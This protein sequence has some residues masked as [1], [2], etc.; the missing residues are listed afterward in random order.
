MNVAEL[1]GRSVM[2][3]FAESDLRVCT[4]VLFPVSKIMLRKQRD[5]K[6]NKTK[7]FLLPLEIRWMLLGGM[8]GG[9]APVPSLLCCT[10]LIGVENSH[11]SSDC[12]TKNKSLIIWC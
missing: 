2:P 8:A 6:E 11:R 12:Y 5:T 9:T 4:P 10:N 1:L 7:S 3:S